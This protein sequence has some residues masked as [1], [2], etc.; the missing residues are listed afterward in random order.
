MSPKAS[1]ILAQA[2]QLPAEERYDL[3]DALHES[4]HA[5]DTTG[6]DPEWSATI[7]RRVEELE[8]GKV[9]AVPWEVVDK[10]VFGEEDEP[11]SR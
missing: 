4:I 3:V 2:M 7:K 9:Q 1:D 5:D 10:M 8:S 11:D 6:I